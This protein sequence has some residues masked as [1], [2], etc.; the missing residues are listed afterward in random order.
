MNGRLGIF[1]PHHVFRT[2]YM[3]LKSNIQ[4]PY[5]NPFVPVVQTIKYVIHSHFQEQ[6]T[7]SRIDRYQ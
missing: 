7:M 4:K 3:N 2:T 5:N 1:K 6:H